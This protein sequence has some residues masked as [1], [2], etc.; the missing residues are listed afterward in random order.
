MK[1]GANSAVRFSSYAALQQAAIDYTKPASGKLGSGMTFGMGA[2]AGLITVCEY[3]GL[4]IAAV[5]LG[6]SGRRLT[7]SDSTMPL[8]NI[9]TRMQSIGAEQKYRHSADCFAKV[10]LGFCVG[11]AY[12]SGDSADC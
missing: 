3:D 11:N 2:I 8:D 10:R 6:A 7:K 9:K 5:P 1:Q 4:L 12:G